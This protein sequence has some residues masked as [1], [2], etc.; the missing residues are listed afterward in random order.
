MCD[1]TLAVILNCA[2]LKDLYIALSD[3]KASVCAFYKK[4]LGD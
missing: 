1:I 4:P 3:Y 2:F